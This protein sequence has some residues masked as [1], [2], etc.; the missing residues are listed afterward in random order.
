MSRRGI[1]ML[2]VLGT[3]LI[4]VTA[5]TATVLAVST[6]KQSLTIAAHERLAEDLLVAS[7]PLVDSWLR[8]QSPRAVADPAVPS[9]MVPITDINL[10][11]G[12][13]LVLTAYDLLGMMPSTAAQ[14]HPLWSVIPGPLRAITIERSG[15]SLREIA[16]PRRPVHP[17]PASG[18]PRLGDVV[19]FNPAFE[20]RSGTDMT[21]LININTVPPPLLEAALRIG[22]RGDVA[23]ILTSRREGRASP[24]PVAGPRA[25][26][27]SMGLVRLIG[28]STLWAVRADVRCG[29]IERSWWTVYQ[30]QGRSWRILERY[31][32]AD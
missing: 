25:T 7:E 3:T 1:A 9:P 24:A 4:V 13:G 6:R 30:S 14:T 26:E 27:R 15:T 32:I 2:L 20:R 12:D 18:A 28:R 17:M 23:S 5:L 19:A 16:D 29:Q 10:D 31:E 11:A 21:V 22:Q 8:R